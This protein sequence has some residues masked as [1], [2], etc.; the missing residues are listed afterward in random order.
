MGD[1]GF[2]PDQCSFFK[3][4]PTGETKGDTPL[5]LDFSASEALQPLT[6]I[7]C[8]LKKVASSSSSM[9][10]HPSLHHHFKECCSFPT[11][12][13]DSEKVINSLTSSPP[14]ELQLIPFCQKS[15]LK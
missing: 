13:R 1:T 7:S 11:F 8:A 14:T 9:N 6:D 5:S 3:S 12:Q 4:A 2:N 10:S 15:N